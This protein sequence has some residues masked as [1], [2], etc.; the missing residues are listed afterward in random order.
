MHE[1]PTSLDTANQT[2]VAS[3]FYYLEFWLS[4]NPYI[5]MNMLTVILS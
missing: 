2:V 4:Y 5:H 1:Q 3:L